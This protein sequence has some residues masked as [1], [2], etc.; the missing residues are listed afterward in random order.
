MDIN[1]KEICN[2]RGY[3]SEIEVGSGR[4]RGGPPRGRGGRGRG[5]PGRHDSRYS[6]N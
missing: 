4:G 5:G 3:N 1:K 6:G 2:S